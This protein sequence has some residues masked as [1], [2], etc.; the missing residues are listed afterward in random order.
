MPKYCVAVSTDV[1]D[2]H[3]V[4]AAI[5]LTAK[6]TRDDVVYDPAS[7]VLEL[8]KPSGEQLPNV[9]SGFTNPAVGTHEHLYVLTESGRLRYKFSGTAGSDASFQA[10]SSG[11]VDVEEN[12]FS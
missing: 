7:I 6:F 3:E 2:S 9:T 1:K 4:G 11:F 5:T 10:A 12:F 8:I